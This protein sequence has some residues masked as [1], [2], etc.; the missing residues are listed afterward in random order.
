VKIYL[1]GPMRG[2]P[3]L[4]RPAFHAAAARLRGD[5]HEV[6]SPAELDDVENNSAMGKEL[7]WICTEAEGIALLPGWRSSRGAKA[8]KATAEAI[9]LHVYYLGPDHYPYDEDP[10]A[11]GARLPD[12]A[13]TRKETPMAAGLLDYFPDALAAVANVSFGGTAQHHPGQ[14]LHW[15]RGKSS[16]HADCIVRHLVDRG[17]LDIDGKRHSVK[18]AWRAL[19]LAQEELEQELGLPPSRGSR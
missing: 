15:E 2:H 11:H 9:D 4:N 14:P 10:F 1:A 3:D 16:D 8:E 12:D 5:G 19:A 18:L 17:S 13:K 7:Q 6:F